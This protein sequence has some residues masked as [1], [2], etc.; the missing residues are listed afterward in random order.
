METEY[1]H[2]V[3][4]FLASPGDLADE[5]KIAKEVVEK[6]NRQVFNKFFNLHVELMGWEDTIGTFGR[7]PQEVI[8]DELARCELFIGML[9]HEWGTSNTGRFSSGFEEEFRLAEESFNGTG[10]PTVAVLFKEMDTSRLRDPGEGLK[11]VLEFKDEIR[12]KVMW[13]LTFDD[14]S[15][16]RDRLET[17]LTDYV[18]RLT[19]EE[20][21]GQPKA[22]PSESDDAPSDKPATDE[23]AAVPQL[24][25]EALAFVRDFADQAARDAD[26]RPITPAEIARFRLLGTLLS[27]HGN[28]DAIIG[29]HDANT[30]F[31]HADELSL[32]WREYSALAEC[33]LVH[34]D[35]QNAPYWRW[36]VA[37][38]AF[39]GLFIPLRTLFGS[40]ALRTG[41]F[42]LMR[43]MQITQFGSEGFNR[44]FYLEKWLSA[45]T[46]KIVREAALGYLGEFGTPVDLLK[47]QEEIARADYQTLK[48]AIHAYASI[49][50]RESVERALQ[51]LM[52]HQ[53]DSVEVELLET[54]FARPSMLPTQLLEQ[55]VSHRAMA[56]RLRSAE[57]LIARRK[58]TREIADALLSDG[59]PEV[60]LQGLL[61]RLS[62]GDTITEEDARTALVKRRVRSGFNYL[63]TLSPSSEGEAQLLKFVR[64]QRETIPKTVLKHQAEKASIF[65]QEYQFEAIRRSFRTRGNEMRDALRD[66]F[67]AWFA[68][69]LSALEAIVGKSDTLEKT[70]ALEDTLRKKWMREALAIVVAQEDC[71]DLPLVRDLV[72]ANEEYLT[73]EVIEFLAQCG[74][75]VDVT[76][77]QRFSESRRG[78]GAGL[79]GFYMS[80]EEVSFAAKALI[81]LGKKR[82]RDL[83]GLSLSDRIKARVI[84]GI[85]ASEFRGLTDDEITKLLSSEN[86][87]VRREAVLK[88]VA[89]LPIVRIK[90]LLKAQLESTEKR[91]YNVCV[92]LDLGVSLDRATASAIAKRASSGNDA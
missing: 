81:K 6:L 52:D 59:E 64:L 76:L 24:P 88:V 5:R 18:R 28:D 70:R 10:R 90:A 86:E 85:P 78:Q 9:F 61:A 35:A 39:D 16:F 40:D 74:E 19:E 22:T 43:L 25:Q 46:P 72:A 66:G 20:R 3:R 51:A 75:W 58:A 33:G 55:G 30:L 83:L 7:R 91:Y 44:D 8:N 11:R 92:W 34:F 82:A 37:A 2:I 17:V 27:E 73:P 56:V 13:G 71:Q 12:T 80:D 67:A 21:R 15:Q 32:A 4:V 54:V 23:P 84:A 79:L 47:V 49:L 45:D 42:K 41:A 63:A 68:K 65:D 14:E 87:S 29:V 60:R 36:L 26:S 89:F 62:L 53:S 31:V 77:I 1:R 69:G 38:N 57:E 48:S 50:S